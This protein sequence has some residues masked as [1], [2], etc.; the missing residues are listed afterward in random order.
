M[1]T[2]FTQSLVCEY[3]RPS[4]PELV[5]YDIAMIQFNSCSNASPFMNFQGLGAR[6][7]RVFSRRLGNYTALLIRGCPCWAVFGDLAGGD[8]I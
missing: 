4:S 8:S 1:T 3:I 7:F 5:S 2:R 6:R